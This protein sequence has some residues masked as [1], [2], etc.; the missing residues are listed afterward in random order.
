MAHQISESD[1][2]DSVD[3]P[4]ARG[5]LLEGITRD[6]IQLD[7]QPIFRPGDPRPAFWE[8]LVR[9]EDRHGELHRPADFLA[10]SERLDLAHPLDR[11]IV[12]ESMRRWRRHSDAGQAVPITINLSAQTAD[13]DLAEHLIGCAAH[14][15]VPHDQVTLEIPSSTVVE[16]QPAATAFI[17][18]LSAAGFHLALDGFDGGA[19]LLNLAR[20]L[21]FDLLKLD[22]SLSQRT[23]T[24]EAHRDHVGSLISL[25]HDHGLAVVAQFVENDK[26]LNVLLG[27]KAD[28]VQ[29]NYLGMPEEFPLDPAGEP[30]SSSNG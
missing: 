16:N 13:A 24:D 11:I 4:R 6:H 20:E 14:W 22:G 27:L 21:G 2:G 25:A 28:F 9:I 5:L 12:N 23:V 7:R 18:M 19:D 15:G 29:G 3:L 17:D 30:T 8:V 26:L 10:Q 1:Q